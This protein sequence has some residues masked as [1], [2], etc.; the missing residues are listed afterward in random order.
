MNGMFGTVLRSL[1]FDVMSTAARTNTA[2]QDVARSPDYKGPSY[3][4]W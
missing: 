1:G 3:N 4:A 2:C